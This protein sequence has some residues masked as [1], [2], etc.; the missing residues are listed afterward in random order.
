MVQRKAEHFLKENNFYELPVDLDGIAKK[1]DILVQAKPKNASGVSGMLLKQGNDFGI[2]YATHIEN[3]GFQRFSIAHEIGHY[4]L[5]G[6]I[7]RVLPNGDGMHISESG[8][9]SQDPYEI[10]AD[11]FASALLMPSE[12]F[13]RAIRK[14]GEGLTAIKKLASLCRTSILAT[15]IR[16]TEFAEEACAIIVSEGN[17]IDYAF[18]SETLKQFPDIEWIRKGNSIPTSAL[19]KTFNA[20]YIGN[21]T[22]E[23]NSNSGILSDWCGEYDLEIQ[24]DVI[25]LGNYGKTLTIITVTQDLEEYE[26]EEELEE[27]LQIRFKK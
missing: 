7:E 10:E 3:D 15:A 6:H 1:L 2:M 25:G 18:M 22:T 14:N 12:L 13:Q 9:T 5:D 26:E 17:N 11:N 27:S 21:C 16:Y 4:I 24:E 19:T 20:K 23:E 8:F